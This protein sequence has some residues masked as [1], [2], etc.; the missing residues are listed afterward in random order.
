MSDSVSR[1][2]DYSDGAVARRD[3]QAAGASVLVHHDIPVTTTMPEELSDYLA[4]DALQGRFPWRR[5]SWEAALHDDQLTLELLHSLGDEVDRESTRTVVL[6]ELA[7]DRVVPAFVAAM[8]WGYGTTGYGPAR[9]RW[10]LTGVRGRAAAAAPIRADVGEKLAMGARVAR[11][12]GPV[13]GFRYMIN[14]GK[15]AYLGGP[16][17]TKWLYFATAVDGIAGP[18]AAPILDAQV[19]RWLRIQQVVS[20][21]VDKTP[22]YE[23]YLRMLTEWGK[24]SGRAPAQVEAGM[25]HL[26]TG[27]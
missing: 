7:A 10:V 12:L 18:N 6:E 2:A 23:T 9:V 11:D 5:S 17:F 1:S 20:L 21:R 4:K 24:R 16:F 8:I 13:E 22:D 15:V 3:P 14:A 19:A 27:R 26:A 25:F